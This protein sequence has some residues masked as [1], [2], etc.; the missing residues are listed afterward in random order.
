MSLIAFPLRVEQYGEQQNEISLE[1]SVVGLP[2]HK[3]GSDGQ[4]SREQSTSTR[5]IPLLGRKLERAS[6]DGLLERVRQGGSDAR[7]L[8]GDA[9]IGKS[10]LLKYAC[11]SAE[12]LQVL[13]VAGVESEMELS[14]SA[15]YQLTLP[16]ADRMSDLPE[17]QRDALR[18]AFALISA[19][20]P[21]P[22]V[23]GLAT[24]ALLARD[25]A[26]DRPMLC[27]IDD[28][29]WLDRESLLVLTFVARRL[30]AEGV[31][32]VFA[33]RSGDDI[34]SS[35]ERL[36][37]LHVRGLTNEDCIKFL[38][39][40]SDHVV[41]GHDADGIIAYTGG[42]PLALLELSPDWNADGRRD[43]DSLASPPLISDVVEARFRR[44]IQELSADG[45]LALLVAASEPSGDAPLFWRV[46]ERL[47][48][49]HR[50]VDQ[51][52]STGLLIVDRGISFRHPLI[53][54][55]TYYGAPPRERRRVH[56]I[57]AEEID[58][59]AD[60]ERRAWH[61]SEATQD[62]DESV[63]A[64]LEQAADRALCRGANS[65][66][67]TFYLRSARFTV[68]A[69][70]RTWR[71]LNAATAYNSS[72]MPLKAQALLDDL[73]PQL[74]NGWFRAQALRLKG[75]ISYSVGRTSETAGILQA[76]ALSLAPFDPAGA[77]TTMLDALSAAMFGG[78]YTVGATT[79]SVARAGRL[80]PPP[81][82][83]ATTITDTLLEG[84]TTYFVD[85][86]EEAAPILKR[87][88]DW[89][90]SGRCSADEECR[91]LI[92][93]GYA[94]SATGDLPRV[95]RLTTRLVQ[96][97]RERGAALML[98]RALHNL[99]VVESMMGTMPAEQADVP[100]IDHVLLY[101]NELTAVGDVLPV[102]CQGIEVLARSTIAAVVADATE[103]RQGWIL[104][105]SDYALA[106]LELALGNY[107]DAFR[108]A[109]RASNENHILVN[110][111]LLPDLVE[112]AVRAG[113]PEAAIHARDRFEVIARTSQEDFPLGMLAR[114]QA[115]TT[116]GESAEAVYREAIRRLK[117]C[118]AHGQLAR[119]HLVFGEWLRR[120]NRRRDSRDELR[121]AL[122]LF[123]L[124]RFEAFAE[125]C[126]RELAATGEHVRK[127]T[128]DGGD[129]LTPQEAQ[130]A[131]LAASGATNR[132]IASQLFI[133]AATVDYHLRK[134]FRKL[135][136][137]S[138]RSLSCVVVENE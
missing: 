49:D 68:G 130:V 85:G 102:A 28:A 114:V 89:F 42:N 104:A 120:Q 121:E 3:G 96:L 47:G 126:R 43:G 18:A 61:R 19:A 67:A 70:D 100:A 14:Y 66:A 38:R 98:R 12:H 92:Y 45:Q 55:A 2:I 136:I 138:R 59:T 94:A 10:A 23:L 76:A 53:R 87:A 60:P 135:G 125:R 9:G 13:R 118:G 62:F 107:D 17:P 27:V 64:E 93:G 21:S 37:V 33:L 25:A 31:G 90:E 82:R 44:Q 116:D 6:L 20:A 65:A 77:R 83:N 15:L 22:F 132:E 81:P 127:R 124:I 78:R 41:E 129:V 16:L 51:L 91:L 131:R 119:A 69:S 115:L 79:V 40:V 34:G 110:G 137:D 1:R 11:D 24:L 113:Q 32:M 48:L 4:D 46:I 88:V 50:T 63:A 71:L 111:V 54:S 105:Y 5:R 8:V 99:A 7:V 72:G 112:A 109:T 134:V 74:E 73:S 26:H 117:M 35:F 56:G 123:E 58:A 80:L 84:L 95:H 103:R 122:R 101:K 30:R 39:A 106:V 133:S 75:N 97:C 57:L 86:V 29:Q 108:H 36:P 128:D 52:E